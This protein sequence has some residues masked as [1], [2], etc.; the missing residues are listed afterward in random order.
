MITS[1][2]FREPGRP[3]VLAKH[4]AKQEVIERQKV[5]FDVAHYAQLSS[6]EVLSGYLNQVHTSHNLEVDMV[7]Q[8][9][10]KFEVWIPAWISYVHP[11]NPKSTGYD[12]IE[13]VVDLE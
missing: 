10:Q 4:S 9:H 7:K 3:T 13:Y 8:M 2:G 12:K 6:S 5:R 1:T 11:A